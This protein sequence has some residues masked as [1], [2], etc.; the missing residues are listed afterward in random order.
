MF[1]GMRSVPA[2][3]TALHRA[4]MF[5]SLRGVLAVVVAAVLL[6][7]PAMARGLLL[8]TLGCYLFIDGLLALGIALR[9]ERGA[10]GRAR[11]ILEGLVS[12]TV[13]ALAFA[14]PT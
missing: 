11:Y 13:G 1:N 6:T 12:L 8:A 14:H 4:W 7:R 10:A 2:G 5:L 3:S 9:A